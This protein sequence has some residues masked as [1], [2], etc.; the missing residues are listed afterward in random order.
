MKKQFF[1]DF[2]DIKQRNISEDLRLISAMHDS[3]NRPSAC[4]C[5]VPVSI[6]GRFAFNWWCQVAMREVSV[7]GLVIFLAI[8]T[9]HCCI[10]IHVS[11]KDAI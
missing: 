8:I 3:D 2:K 10:F 7:R 11:I 4:Y 5:S 6:T 9:R 1:W